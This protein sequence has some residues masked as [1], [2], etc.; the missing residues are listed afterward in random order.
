MTQWPLRDFSEPSERLKFLNHGDLLV[1]SAYK[2]FHIED[3]NRTLGR[4][5]A[6]QALTHS[7]Q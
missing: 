4:H 3:T 1:E 2:R 6:K 5:Y 7:I